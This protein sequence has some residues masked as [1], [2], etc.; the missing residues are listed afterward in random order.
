[1]IKVL[2]SPSAEAEGLVLVGAFAT[3][4]PKVELKKK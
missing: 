1:M 3:R 4:E 2:V